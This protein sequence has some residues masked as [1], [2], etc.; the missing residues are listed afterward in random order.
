MMTDG[1]TEIVISED[2]FV[3][4]HFLISQHKAGKRIT[5]DDIREK[6]PKISINAYNDCVGSPTSNYLVFKNYDEGEYYLEFNPNRIE[7]ITEI[8][9][10]EAKFC[11]RVAVVCSNCG[12]GAKEVVIKKRIPFNS[13]EQT[14]RCDY[15]EVV[16]SYV[17]V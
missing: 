12:K 2:I 7:E 1:K 6:L 8:L 5:V 17:R 10:Q 11:Y 15:C 13:W 9:N 3:L 4:I 16:G 14:E